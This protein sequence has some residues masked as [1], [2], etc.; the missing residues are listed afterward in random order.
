MVEE[1]K[2]KI[3]SAYLEDRN[4]TKDRIGGIVTRRFP[5]P[6]KMAMKEAK[7]DQSSITDI[8]IVGVL[9]RIPSSGC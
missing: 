5:D 6:V 9:T 4:T 2:R 3:Y 1:V 8:V 7:T